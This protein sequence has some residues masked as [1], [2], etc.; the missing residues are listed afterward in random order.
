MWSSI[1]LLSQIIVSGSQVCKMKLQLQTNVQKIC[2]LRKT[3]S[4]G[5]NSLIALMIDC[6]TFK[7]IHP[8]DKVEQSRK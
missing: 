2:Q 1:L 5:M 4:M 3:S 7:Y 6:N 8:L